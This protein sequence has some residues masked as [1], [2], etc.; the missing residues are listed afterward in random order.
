MSGAT[1]RS[2]FFSQPRVGRTSGP[3]VAGDRGGEA[4]KAMEW[5]YREREEQ[6]AILREDVERLGAG[7]RLLSVACHLHLS[8]IF[9]PSSGGQRAGGFILTALGQPIHFFLFLH[10]MHAT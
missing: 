10:L 8:F 5:E 7:V 9:P 2:S 6:L 1:K 4:S 3:P